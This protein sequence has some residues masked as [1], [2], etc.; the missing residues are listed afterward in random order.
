MPLNEKLLDDIRKVESDKNTLDSLQRYS[1]PLGEY[2]WKLK[3]K[4]KTLPAPERKILTDLKAFSSTSTHDFEEEEWMRMYNLCKQF[5]LINGHIA[6]VDMVGDN[7]IGR[8]LTAVRVSSLTQRKATK[9]QQ[10]RI[11]LLKDLET[12]RNWS[13]YRKQTQRDKDM[14]FD[15]DLQEDLNNFAKQWSRYKGNT[16]P[17]QKSDDPHTILQVQPG[18]DE[19]V[20][21]AAYRALSLIC[22]PDKTGGDSTV[23]VK[24]Q[25]AYE[26]LTKKVMFVKVL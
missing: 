25:R 22:H 23:Y 2:I 10:N 1:K 13:K 4:F 19:S 20:I 17:E 9:V 12:I 21:R 14:K 16:K 5:E 11:L 18:A 24:I 26:L 15:A 7:P 8:W 3:T 6:H